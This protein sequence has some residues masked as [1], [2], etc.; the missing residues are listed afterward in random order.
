MERI[1]RWT[2]H[3]DER[4]VFGKSMRLEFQIG[5]KNQSIIKK[6]VTTV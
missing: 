6:V 1:N 4:K 3:L 2:P 5:L